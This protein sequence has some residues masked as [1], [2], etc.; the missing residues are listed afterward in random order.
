MNTPI[1][2]FRPLSVMDSSRFLGKVRSIQFAPILVSKK[3]SSNDALILRRIRQAEAPSW[4]KPGNMYGRDTPSIL[5]GKA[6]KEPRRRSTDIA[7]I[8]I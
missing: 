5:P 6:E 4:T 1:S 7:T 8:S 2:E 3:G